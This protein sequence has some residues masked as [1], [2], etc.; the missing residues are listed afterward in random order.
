[1]SDSEWFSRRDL[2]KRWCVSVETVRRLEVKGIFTGV[3]LNKR[4]VR[5][6]VAEIASLEVG[7]KKKPEVG[8]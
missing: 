4:L 2:A 5:Y 3:Y 6:S 8:L 7:L 1:M